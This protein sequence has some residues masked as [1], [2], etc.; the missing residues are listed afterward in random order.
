MVIFTGNFEEAGK[1]KLP[2]RPVPQPTNY[3]SPHPILAKLALRNATN[4]RHPALRSKHKLENIKRI[5]VG[6][7]AE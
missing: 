5:Q 3:C 4:S 1:R 6:L 2:Q 7:K